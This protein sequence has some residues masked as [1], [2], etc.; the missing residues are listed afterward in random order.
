MVHLMGKDILVMPLK[1]FFIFYLSSQNQ[2]YNVSDHTMKT[3]LCM[4]MSR[5]RHGPLD[6]QG[7]TCHALEAIFHLLPVI[8]KSDL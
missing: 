3:T 1:Q 2:T 6:G 4:D 7:Y 8:P 5:N